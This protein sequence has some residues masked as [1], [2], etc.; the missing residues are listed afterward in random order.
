MH[1]IILLSEI[2]INSRKI[3]EYFY[4]TLDMIHGLDLYVYYIVCYNL[5][6]L[7][8]IQHNCKPP[9]SNFRQYLKMNLMF[10]INPVYDLQNLYATNVQYVKNWLHLKTHTTSEN[11]LPANIVNG[12]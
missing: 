8:K 4:T 7:R 5:V 2:T 9:F 11:A 1:N 6:Q 3:S 10:L 12:L